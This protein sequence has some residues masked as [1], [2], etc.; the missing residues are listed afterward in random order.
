M[1]LLLHSPFSEL[2]VI[3]V[4]SDFMLD[5]ETLA[6][7]IAHIMRIRCNI[8]PK[9][10]FERSPYP[11]TRTQALI[12]DKSKSLGWVQKV[13]IDEGIERTVPMLAEYFHQNR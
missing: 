11:K 1:L 6:N 13:G 2:D 9:L 7:K 4:C 5:A 12:C 10:T 8:E 3:N